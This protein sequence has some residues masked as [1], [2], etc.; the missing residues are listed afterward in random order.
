M[1]DQDKIVYILNSDIPDKEKIDRLF[2][3]L[4]EAMVYDVREVVKRFKNVYDSSIN[5]EAVGTLRPE[6]SLENLRSHLLETINKME[7]DIDDYIKDNNL[8][9]QK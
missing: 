5:Y 7:N 6:D 3:I 1:R 2:D 9:V 4:Q 8:K